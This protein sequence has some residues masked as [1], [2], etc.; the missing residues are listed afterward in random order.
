MSEEF[1]WGVF[2]IAAVFIIAVF[3]FLWLSSGASWAAP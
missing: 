3:A 2:A 1:D